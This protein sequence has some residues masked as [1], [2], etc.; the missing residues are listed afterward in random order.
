MSERTYGLSVSYHNVRLTVQGCPSP[1]S[2][3]ERAADSMRRDGWKPRKWWQFW[4]W[5]EPTVPAEV[6]KAW[7]E[8]T[9]E[10]VC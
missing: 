3:A 9:K 7:H 5:L 10:R 6:I 1:D 2:A 8:Q 4:R